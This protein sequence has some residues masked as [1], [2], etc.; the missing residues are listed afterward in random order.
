MVEFGKTNNLRK[1]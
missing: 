1:V